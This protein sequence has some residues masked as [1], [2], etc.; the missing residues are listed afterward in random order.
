VTE[1]PRPTLWGYIKSFFLRVGQLCI[2][3]PLA[4]AATLILICLA[5][6]MAIFGKQ[7]QIGGILGRLWGKKESPDD[8]ILHPPSGRVDPSTGKVIEPGQPDPGGFVQPMPVVI[9]DPGILSDPNKI[10]VIDP[11]G[12]SVDVKL[13]TGVKNEDVKQVIMVAPNVFQIANHDSGVDAGK[14]LEDLTK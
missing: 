9:K 14:L 12:K 2:R 3:Y 7:F 1:D 10:T 6:S 5:I 4:T 11:S 8:P 13:P